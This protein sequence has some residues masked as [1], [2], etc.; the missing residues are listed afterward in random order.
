MVVDDFTSLISNVGFPISAFILMWYT[1]NRTLKKLTDAIH[2]LKDCIK[3]DE[4]R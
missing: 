1:H 3:I 4:R 2:E